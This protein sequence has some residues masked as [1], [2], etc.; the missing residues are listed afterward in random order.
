MLELNSDHFVRELLTS[1]M[2][3]EWRQM[4]LGSIA[5][6]FNQP[7]ECYNQIHSTILTSVLFN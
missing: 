1:L 2:A 4:T 6:A 3:C 7:F 5:T